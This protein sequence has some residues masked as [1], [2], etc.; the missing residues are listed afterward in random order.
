MTKTKKISWILVAALTAVS[1]FAGLWGITVAAKADSV[2]SVTSSQIDLSVLNERHGITATIGPGGKANGYTYA[3]E[4]A[5]FIDENNILYGWQ[6]SF[7]NSYGNHKYAIVVPKAVVGVSTGQGVPFAGA[8]GSLQNECFVGISFESGSA[9]TYV[10]VD[11]FSAARNLRYAVLPESIRRID[12][13][14]FFECNQL[15]D[16]VL[17]EGLEEIGNHSFVGCSNLLHITIPSTVTSIS[18]TAFTK[19]DV[20]GTAA[21]LCDIEYNADDNDS[22]ALKAMFP[23]ALNIYGSGAKLSDSQKSGKSHLIVTEDGLAFCKNFLRTDTLASGTARTYNYEIGRWY[24]VGLMGREIKTTADDIYGGFYKFPESMDLSEERSAVPYDYLSSDAKGYKTTITET[25]VDDYDIGMRA[26]YATWFCRA[27]FGKAVKIIGDYAFESSHLQYADI[28]ENVKAIGMRGLRGGSST[29]KNQFF[30]IRAKNIDYG[31]E[32]MHIGPSNVTD[33][34]RLLICPDIDVYGNVITGENMT[35]I[36]RRP[37]V[38]TYLNGT[39]VGSYLIDIYLNVDTDGVNEKELFGTRLY[40]KTF[41]YVADDKGMWSTAAETIADPNV[42]GNLSTV[43]Y[44]D[45]AYTQKIEDIS[46][47][48]ES[49]DNG[50]IPGVKEFNLYTKKI[51]VPVIPPNKE[52]TYNEGELAG[53]SGISYV[54]AAGFGDDYDAVLADTNGYTL[55]SGMASPD[56]PANIRDAGTYKVEVRLGEKWGVWDLNKIGHHGITVTVNRAVV[57]LNKIALNWGLEGESVGFMGS[58]P[59]TLYLYDDGWYSQKKADPDESPSQEATVKNSF[60]RYTGKQRTVTVNA[61]EASEYSVSGRT[62]IFSAAS[63]GRY[64]LNVTLSMKTHNYYFQYQNGTEEFNLRGI[65]VGNNRDAGETV[66]VSKTW[67]IVMQSNWVT[68]NDPDGGGEDSPSF[69]IANVAGWTYGDTASKTGVP[70]EINTPMLAFGGQ[71]GM[72]FSVSLDGKDITGG[73]KDIADFGRYVNLSMPAG[74]YGIIITGPEFNDGTTQYPVVKQPYSLTV[75]PR[76]LTDAQKNVLQTALSGQKF[77]HRYDGSVYIHDQLDYDDVTAGDKM[78]SSGTLYA[79]LET[80]LHALRSSVADNAWASADFDAYYTPFSI[81]YNL[82]R[83]QS[84]TYY[85]Y[86]G[87]LRNTN[88]YVPASVGVYTVYYQMSAPSYESLWTS[89]SLRRNYSFTTV[90]YRGVD[91][92]IVNSQIYVGGV[93]IPNIPYSQA[94]TYEYVDSDN[95]INVGDNYEVKF[96]LND[97]VLYR[98]NEETVISGKVTLGGKNNEI[99]TVKFSITPGENTWVVRPSLLGW[100]WKEFD[101]G[102]NAVTAETRYDTAVYFRIYNLYEGEYLPVEFID[103][104]GLKKN[105]FVLNSDGMLPDWVVRGLKDLKEGVYYIGARADGSGNFGPIE[106]AAN[107]YSMFRVNAAINVWTEIPTIASWA[108]NVWHKDKNSPV[109]EAKYGDIHIIV[110]ND[111]TETVYFEGWYLADGT[112]RTPIVDRLPQAPG[113]WY[114]MSAVVAQ[115]TGRYSGLSAAVKF[116]VF[117]SGTERPANNWHNAALP[118][119]DSWVAGDTPSTPKGMALRG[120]TVFTY[121]TTKYD[122]EA[123]KYVKDEDLGSSV[124][125][126]PG[127]YIL[128]AVVDYYENGVL[129]EYDHLEAEVDFEIFKR[130][131][132]WIDNPAILSWELSKPASEPVASTKEDGVIIFEYKQKILSDDTYTTVKPTAAGE[133]V[134]RVTATA[135]N[136][137][138][139][140]ATVEFT[141]SLSKNHWIN[142]PTIEDW[143]E[144]FDPNNPTG[145]AEIGTVTYIYLNAEDRSVLSE[146]PTN[147]GT[148]ILR[149]VV[150]L[151]GYETLENEFVFTISAAYDTSLINVN[152]ALG[153]IACV[154]TIVVI[155][156]AVRRYKQC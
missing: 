136:C 73:E 109:A 65:T 138:P 151:E 86:T 59:T 41:D 140:V 97:S 75:A 20:N 4:D 104:S 100:T 64:M 76:A 78:I 62:G 33:I 45:S 36:F 89:E 139:L 24:F 48:I 105:E 103:N 10:G 6:R 116:Q 56:R 15:R 23:Y 111:E 87:M 156:F 119:I 37:G 17:P 44:K 118:G 5:L 91:V 66:D 68:V 145:K 141:V 70:I 12:E 117:L 60:V 98:W 81:S 114:T 2:V 54:D 128:R 143:S 123:H 32:S 125:S 29:N 129:I 121:W 95:Y 153:V 7:I 134:M 22:A 31:K 115:S 79:L 101:A 3:A 1:L 74:T 93:V 92:P 52:Y 27:D 96:T 130:V 110:K 16:I 150:E 51:G 72:K 84:S 42:D 9:L 55:P 63:S 49:G 108:Q 127:R 94:Y 61:S 106:I 30:Y 135:E 38:D 147:E 8:D 13:R 18:S 154:F 69:M 39:V 80:E 102:N 146:K 14:G 46:E 133:Y 148:Y 107:E 71:S 50:L 34:K 53:G 113:G 88:L 132:E 82:D 26:C 28:G 152:I 131:N 99:A 25:V 58:E 155:V 77:E 67:Y 35:N 83:M 90:I 40:N 126:A 47:Y 112:K 19:G 43:W 142:L 144:E 124:P 120:D 21:K 57:D 85:T 149:A 11:A 137:E 122:D